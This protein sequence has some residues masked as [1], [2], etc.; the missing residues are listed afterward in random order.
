MDKHIK[1]LHQLL[2]LYFKNRD[3]NNLAQHIENKTPTGNTF[4]NTYIIERLG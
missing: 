2:I 3:L 4:I 1:I